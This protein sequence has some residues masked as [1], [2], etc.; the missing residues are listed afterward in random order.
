MA[1]ANFRYEAFLSY[2]HTDSRWANWLHR[3]IETY[4]VPKRLVAAGT[5]A[6]LSP[7][8]R[9]REELPSASNLSQKIEEA[10]AGSRCLIVVCSPRAAA[11]RWVNEEIQRFKTL[12]RSDRIFAI[13][14]D[15]EPNA[16]KRGR[17][18][19]QECFPEALRIGAD[20]L[21]RE[22]VAADA[23][24]HADGRRNAQ[25]KIIAGMLGVGLD[26]L[27]RRD[28]QRRQRRLVAITIASVSG[29]IVATTLA[30]FAFL[31]RRDAER[32]AQTSRRTTDFMVQLFDV[33]DPGEARG[34]SVT[35]YEILEKG[36]GQIHQ[37]NDAPEVQATLLETMGRVFTGLGLY[38]KAEGL[39]T[40]A[41]TTRDRTDA[42]AADSLRAEVALA[43]AQYLAG[44]YTAAENHYR[45]ALASISPD[46]AWTAASS[47]ALNGLAD[48]LAQKGEFADAIVQYRIALARDQR[49]WGEASRQTARTLSGLASA[50]LFDEKTDEAKVDF[51]AAL[52]SYRAS[53]GDDHPKVAETINNLGA[54]YYYT[55]DIAGAA[56]YYRLALPLYRKVYGEGHPEIAIILN[57]LARMEL[58]LGDVDA[59]LPLLEESVSIDRSLGRTGHDD[60]VLGLSN[61]AIAYKAKGDLQRSETLLREAR[62]L[63]ASINHRYWGPLLVDLAD[64]SCSTHREADGLARLSES[65]PKIRS[66]Y[67]DEP[68][69]MA[70]LE[71]VKGG[72]LSAAGRS[73][74][75]ERILLDSYAVVAARWGNEGLFTNEARR[76]VAQYY[77][78][79][80]NMES[81]ARYRVPGNT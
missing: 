18:A 25:L 37:L 20:G 13:I 35:A 17:D 69:R 28:L 72:C 14:V 67:P 2:S 74:E 1:T 65:E 61:L 80:G 47:G 63:A 48:V 5:A 54:V 7:V 73:A 60:F 64:I 41:L 34:R 19:S 31:A 81:A 78:R 12:G 22:H 10:L 58:E 59:A 53:L 8:F 50:L 15:G 52:S 24:A 39:L 27:K 79:I 77:E 51:E 40:E 33:V 21:P 45:Q 6:R 49:T 55:G 4:R 38:G 32:E 11:S 68:W 44:S 71:S 42:N 29:L 57:N 70:L 43:D 3:G 9:D 23:R 66:V 46:T 36:V 62:E 16:A 26:D 56:R 75:T 76:R 30:A